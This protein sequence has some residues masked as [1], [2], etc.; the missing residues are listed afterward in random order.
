M[1]YKRWLGVED[2][3]FD[4]AN[5]LVGSTPVWTNKQGVGASNHLDGE[6]RFHDVD[7]TDTVAAAA[8]GSETNFGLQVGFNLKSDEGLELAG[9]ALDDFCVVG[10]LAADICTGDD[11]DTAAS[12]TGCCSANQGFASPLLLALAALGLMFFRRRRA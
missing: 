5:V 6:W 7:I 4:S 9:W 2:S 10:V 8:V 11:C 1:Q 12:E 3:T